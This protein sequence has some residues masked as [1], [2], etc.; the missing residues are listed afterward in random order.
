MD[1]REMIL[2]S[3]LVSRAEMAM[4]TRNVS[5]TLAKEKPR[6]ELKAGELVDGVAAGVRRCL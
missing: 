3:P 6:A 1:G 5:R 2:P 4:S